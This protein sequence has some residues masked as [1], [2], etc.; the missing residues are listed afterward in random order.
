[1][2]TVMSVPSCRS[3][4]S[5]VSNGT[6]AEMN[7]AYK[8]YRTHFIFLVKYEAMEIAKDWNYD[9]YNSIVNGYFP[10]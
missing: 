5:H 6:L 7:D 4:A 3:P 10:K 2:A 8:F 9:Y 1:M